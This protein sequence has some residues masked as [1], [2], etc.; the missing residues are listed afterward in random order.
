MYKWIMNRDEVDDDDDG[1]LF[2]VM[3]IITLTREILQSFSL[4][5][6]TLINF[7]EKE[8]STRFL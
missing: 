5:I 1:K 2:N 6:H 4:Y 7:D 3:L 8:M